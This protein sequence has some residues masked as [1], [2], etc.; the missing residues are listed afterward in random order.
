MLNEFHRMAFRKK[1][2]RTL[3]E[4][5]ADLDAWLQE[6]NEQRPPSKAAGGMQRNSSARSNF[7]DASIAGCV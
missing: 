4:L 7:I 5:Q 2:C 6:Y 3:E 1:I